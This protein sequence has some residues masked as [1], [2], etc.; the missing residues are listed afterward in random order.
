MSGGAFAR[1]LE[2]LREW[3]LVV[4]E[5]EIPL[6]TERFKSRTGNSS[7]LVG[8]LCGEGDFLRGGAAPDRLLGEGLRVKGSRKSSS[9][10][11]S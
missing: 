3:L 2:H 6:E 8:E 5:R 10:S 1:V 11:A 7:V 9:S 4:K